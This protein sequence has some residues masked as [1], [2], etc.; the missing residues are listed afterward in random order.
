[1]AAVLGTL[2]GARYKTAHFSIADD[3]IKCDYL[4]LGKL[5]VTFARRFHEW[6]ALNSAGYLVLR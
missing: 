1:M 3:I 6:A 5:Y 4:I 2:Q